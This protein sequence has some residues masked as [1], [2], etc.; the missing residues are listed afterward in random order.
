MQLIYT[1]QYS[2]DIFNFVF[3]NVFI[4][5]Y[6]KS[7]KKSSLGINDQEAESLEPLLNGKFAVYKNMLRVYS[8]ERISSQW[9]LKLPMFSH[10]TLYYFFKI[11]CYIF[12]ILKILLKPLWILS[13]LIKHVIDLP[14]NIKRD[15]NITLSML[16]N[17]FIE[18]LE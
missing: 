14:W 10:I 2:S 9:H 11:N 16:P 6:R 17:F 7:S 8:M 3:M 4:L 18:R 1:C 12:S 5:V 13:D 15:F